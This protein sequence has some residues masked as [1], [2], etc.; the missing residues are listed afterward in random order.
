VGS[1]AAVISGTGS[2]FDQVSSATVPRRQAVLRALGAFL[3]YVALSVAIWGWPTIA[4]LRTRYVTPG[5]SDPNFYR[6]ALGWAPWALTHGQNLVF[7]DRVFAPQGL[8]LTWIAFIPGPAIVMAPITRTFGTLTSYNLLVL[9]APAL[10]AWGTYLV[11]IRLTRSFWPSF[12]AGVLYGFSAYIGSQLNHPN[13]SLIFPLPLAVYLVIRRLEGSLG[14]KAFVSLLTLTLLALF[15]IS[16][17]IFATSVVFG[18]IAWCIAIASSREERG[19]LLRTLL[20]CGVAYV[21]VAA[22]VLIPYLLPALRTIPARRLHDPSH[23][24]DDL[25]RFVLPRERVLV[26]KGI[27]GSLADRYTA[28]SLGAAAY[29]GIA[30]VALL[31][32]FGITERRRRGTWGLLGFIAAGAVLTLGPTSHVAGTALGLP[33]AV[34]WDLPIISNALPDRFPMYTDLAIA[35]VAAIWLSRAH[36]PFAWWRWALVLVGALM[37]LPAVRTPPWHAKDP[38]PA[39][40]TDGTYASQLHPDENVFLITDTNAQEM[41]WQAVAGF[42]FRMPGGYVGAI[43]AANDG[44]ALKRGFSAQQGSVPGTY[45]LSSWLTDNMVSAI[46]VADRAR[47]K[48]EQVLRS[49]GWA[50][51]HEGGGVSVWR[52]APVPTGSG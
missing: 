32:A 38:T 12:L 42:W 13:L 17:E 5:G 3:C 20:L 45:E 49:V 46:V 37:V 10:A 29:I 14:V 9:L 7:T 40:F 44:S 28:A 30:Q 41:A 21:L 43:P 31:V 51:T 16:T 4:H 24:Y 25:L 2:A 19:P 1:T 26:G 27:L 23:R 50:P 52:S 6:W 39:F 18:T 11:C 33:T 34:I 47:S 36:G 15:S 48:C 8:E 35:I 22:I